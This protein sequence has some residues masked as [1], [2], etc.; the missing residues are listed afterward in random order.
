MASLRALRTAASALKAC[1]TVAPTSARTFAQRS[2]IVA[3][4]SVS[5]TWAA[6]VAARSFSLSARAFGQ[7]ESDVELSTKLQEEIQYEKEASEQ[8]GAEP[9]FVKEFKADGVWKIEH[10][11]GHDE[12]ALVRQFGNETVRVIFS[13]GDIDTPQEVNEYDEEGNPIAQDEDA[14]SNPAFAIRCAITITKP[15]TG[16]LS[17]D[18]VAEDGNFA[19]DNVSYYADAK[20]AGELSAE[21]DW[22]RRGLYIGP[23]FDHLDV[24][25]QEAFEK[26]LDERDIGP[27]LASFIPEFAEWKEQKEYTKW[28][29]QVHKFVS[30]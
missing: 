10:Q 15:N 22:K 4:P 20:L 23:Q 9:D 17:I 25:V 6:P 3:G 18:A 27:A 2:A 26:Y 1:R 11:D 24:G 13:I 12:V 16:A 30:A 7:G 8:A 14:T 29:E 21:A 5:R 28:L 19:V